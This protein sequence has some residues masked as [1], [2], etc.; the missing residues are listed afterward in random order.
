MGRNW[1]THPSGEYDFIDMVS[2]VRDFNNNRVKLGVPQL[3]PWQ[4]N[5]IH[6][7]TYKNPEENKE[8]YKRNGKSMP[9]RPM[10]NILRNIRNTNYHD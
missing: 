3:G 8:Y 7:E 1:W 2:W 9:F 10:I 4:T 5:Y 6:A